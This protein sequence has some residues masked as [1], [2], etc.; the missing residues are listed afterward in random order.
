[1]IIQHLRVAVAL[2]AVAL[3][4]GCGRRRGED[5]QRSSLEAVDPADHARYDARRRDWTGSVGRRDAGVQRRCRTRAPV[6]SGVRNGAGDA[7]VAHLDDD[8]PLPCRT[9]RPR[10]R[11]LARSRAPARRRAASRRGLSYRRVRLRVRAGEAVR[12][13]AR[14]STSTTTS[15]PAMPW[16]APP[17]R[18]RRGRCR[19]LDGAGNSAALRLGPFLRAARAVRSRRTRSDRDSRRSRTSARSRRWISEIGRLVQGFEQRVAASRRRD[20]D[21]HRRRSRGR[22]WRSRRIAARQPALPVDDARAAGR[23][24]ARA[25]RWASARPR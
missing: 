8:R 13:G 18:R 1:M 24:P 2:L 9:R 14:A 12:P 16:S 17:M 20:R 4:A 19:S 10:E 7:A 6:S 5:G 21:R 3:C 23:W 11:P 25:W 22:A 15:S